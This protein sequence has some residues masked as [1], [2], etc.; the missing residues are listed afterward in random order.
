[1]SDS[2]NPT[3]FVASVTK[4]A[5]LPG[6]PRGSSLHEILDNYGLTPTE[7]PEGLRLY[8]HELLCGALRAVAEIWVNPDGEVSSFRVWSKKPRKTRAKAA[9]GNV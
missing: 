2:P 8:K 9:A 4:Q 1:M 6:I 3:G 5:D 7:A